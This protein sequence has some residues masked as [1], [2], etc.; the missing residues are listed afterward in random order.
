MSDSDEQANIEQDS[1]EHHSPTTVWRTTVKG[2]GS[3][4]PIANRFERIELEADFE[5]LSEEDQQSELTKKIKTEFFID[6]SETVVSENS[7]PDV[8][9]NFS[10]NPYRGCAHGCSYC[11]ARPT[12]EYLGLN[13]GID[14]E[15]KIMVKPNAAALF[16]KWLS[17][18]N[19]KSSVE[20]IMLSGVTDCYQPCEK[21]F[22]LTRRCLEVALD[23]RQPMRIT[24]K[25]RLVARDLDL[26]SQMAEQQLICVTVSLSSLDQSLVR[27]MEPRSSSPQARLDSIKQLTE[28][29]VP[30]K[31]LVAPI[32]PALNDHEIPE[33]LDKVSEAGATHAGYVV[34]RLPLAVEPVFV[35]WAERNFPDRIEKI[36]SRV[37]SM[38]NG[39]VYDS[40]FGNRMKGQGIWGEQIKALFNTVCSKHS[41]KLGVPTLN[42]NAFRKPEPDFG[43]QK[44]LF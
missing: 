33:I 44:R 42:C 39:K 36:L 8:D 4:L 24:T 40:S 13:A 2:R 23:A 12:H 28:A 11:Y 7:S 32:I 17:R 15:S 38:S 34:L 16:K 30:V 22:E 3:S 26:L 21:G 27:I 5:Q 37:Q 20:P 31:V 18:K 25:N 10:L 35:D 19:W 29:G 6:Q 41:L 43:N 9:F 14:F 1:H